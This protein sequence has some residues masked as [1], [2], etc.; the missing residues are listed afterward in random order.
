MLKVIDS[1]KMGYLLSLTEGV[2][3]PLVSNNIFLYFFLSYLQGPVVKFCSPWYGNSNPKLSQW[4]DRIWPSFIDIILRI[5]GTS[6][7]WFLNAEMKCLFISEYPGALFIKGHPKK[8]LV[9]VL[10]EVVN[11]TIFRSG[12]YLCNDI[13]LLLA[14]LF[15]FFISKCIKICNF[16]I[17]G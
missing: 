5:L 2:G 4:Q 11:L 6:A 7:L 10:F 8:L 16:R 15:L 14:V 9:L 12:L 3:V 13:F 1:K 17:S